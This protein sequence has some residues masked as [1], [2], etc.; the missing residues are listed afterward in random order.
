MQH[1]K[2]VTKAMVTKIARNAQRNRP[3]A[4]CC[5]LMAGTSMSSFC[6]QF[7]E[8][9]GQDRER[10]LRLESKGRHQRTDRSLQARRLQGFSAGVKAPVT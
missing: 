5:H 7:E 10:E 6:R 4:G 9:T 8:V 1:A 2:T 3:L